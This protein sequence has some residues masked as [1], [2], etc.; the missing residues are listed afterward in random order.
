MPENNLSNLFKNKLTVFTKTNCDDIHITA[1]KVRRKSLF[2]VG[3][4]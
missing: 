2:G 4:K 3:D 1:D